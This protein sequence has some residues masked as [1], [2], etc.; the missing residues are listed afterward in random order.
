MTAD[1]LDTLPPGLILIFGAF[2]VPFLPGVLRKVWMLALP[3]LAFLQLLGFEPG[4]HGTTALFDLELIPVRV[5]KLSLIF[6]YIFLLATLL[7]VIYQLHLTGWLEQ[8]ATLIYAGS[9][10]GAVFAGDL[11]SL[12][13]F[14]EGTAIASVFLVWASRTP[15][16]VAA[17]QRYVVIQIASGMLLLAGTMIHHGQTGSINFDSFDVRTAAGVLIFL[18]FGVK[19]AF[20]LLHFWL[21]DAYPQATATGAVVLSAFTTKLAI[22]A[23]ARSFAGTEILIHIGTVMAVFPILFALIE[24]DLRRVLAYSL[25]SQLGFMVLGVG[26]GT[27]LSLAGTAAHAVCSVLYQGL[28]FMTMGAVLLR[29]GTTKVS[30]LGGLYRSMPLT[31]LFCCIGA[32]SIS[33]F[34][35]FSGFVSKSLTVSAAL[36]GEYMLTWMALVLASAAAFLHSGVRVPML[37]FFG[38]DSGLRPKEA[39]TNMLVAMAVSAM[40][41]LAIGL[42]PGLLHGLLPGEV[43]YDAYTLEHLVTQMQILVFAGVV[44]V[45]F[46]RWNLSPATQRV[47]YIDVDWLWRKPLGWLAGGIHRGLLDT[48]SGATSQVARASGELSK[49]LYLEHGSTGHLAR[50]RPSGSMALYMAVLL[51]AFMAFSFF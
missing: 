26:I 48:L 20:P 19:A 9:A 40:L 34:P 11:V 7:S 35:F 22:Y 14:W 27:E 5:D 18:S 13:L 1:L 2:L 28:L 49:K 41:C 8:T 46:L 45:L 32:A 51:V 38:R 16:A 47:I 21:K 4:V 3:V 31:T 10:V 50:T 24:N 6:G 29:T 25:N 36:K 42:L 30:D 44:Y 23:L 12:F 37:A 15:Q 43:K 39:P 17:G 33:A